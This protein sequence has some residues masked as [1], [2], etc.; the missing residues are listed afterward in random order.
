M[1]RIEVKIS[2][3]SGA[4]IQDEEEATTIEVVHPDFSQAIQLDALISDLDGK[5]PDAQD[6][7]VVTPD[8]QQ[9]GWVA[10][11][12]KNIRGK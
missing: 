4:F 7:V 10:A 1:A 3:L 9:T 6:F 12:K 2:D 8:D 11:F 5:L